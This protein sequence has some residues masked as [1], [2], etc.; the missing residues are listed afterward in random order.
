MYLNENK[1]LKELREYG[2]YIHH[3]SFYYDIDIMCRLVFNA[4]RLD[5]DY[6]R[7]IGFECSDLMDYKKYKTNKVLK[8]LKDDG[9]VVESK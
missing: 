1:T 2:F 6:L 9:F 3:F 7:Y 4:N 8:K 5:D